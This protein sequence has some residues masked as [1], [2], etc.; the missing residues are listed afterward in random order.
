MQKNI[1]DNFENK[2]EKLGN[3]SIN[4]LK[5]L[6]KKGHKIGCHS[7]THAN[8]GLLKDKIKLKKEILVSGNTLEKLLDININHFA[9]T[10][11][12]F[13]SMSEKSLKIALPRYEFIYSCLRGNNFN[14]NKKTIIKRDTVY[15]NKG[16]DLLN[17]FLSGIIDLKYLNQVRKIN[18]LIQNNLWKMIIAIDMVGTNKG[19]GTK[20]YNLNF[21]NIFTN[22]ILK[23]KIYIFITKN[24]LKNMNLPHRSNIN[25]I[26]KPI[27]L[28]NI[29]F[30]I[31]WMQLFLPFELKK[32]KVNQLFSPM[33]IGP[34][35]IKF[36][37]I[38][39]TLGLH[40]NLP[41]TFFSKM[42]GN[43]FRKVLTKY[44]MESSIRNCDKLIVNSN[45]A[46]MK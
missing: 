43:F 18:R 37:K 41:W 31:I 26:F 36:F 28:E 44:F 9:F 17:I 27:F 29:F 45:F 40:S 39:L 38:K 21:V 19:S 4:N 5:T 1:L 46:K 33:N 13:N 11:G 23:K 32:L 14:N 30:R 3:I 7:K 2:K 35:F 15:L 42:P 16:N 8:L 10:Y 6:I 12:N 20:T 25:Y 34:I 22:K 24:Y